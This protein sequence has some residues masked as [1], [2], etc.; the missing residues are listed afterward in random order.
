MEVG[1]AGQQGR[2]PRAREDLQLWHPLKR[3]IEPGLCEWGPRHP[4]QEAYSRTGLPGR[5]LH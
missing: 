3:V 5:D 1:S 4:L 2:D